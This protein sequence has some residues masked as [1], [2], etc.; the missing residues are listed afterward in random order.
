MYCEGPTPNAQE[1][2][3]D[4]GLLSGSSSVFTGASLNLLGAFP[5]TLSGLLISLAVS[6]FSLQFSPETPLLFFSVLFLSTQVFLV[7]RLVVGHL[8]PWGGREG[9]RKHHLC[10]LGSRG[11]GAAWGVKGSGGPVAPRRR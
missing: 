7:L 8:G 3:G 1:A 4:S 9:T 10:F 6:P 5:V 11:A 2:R